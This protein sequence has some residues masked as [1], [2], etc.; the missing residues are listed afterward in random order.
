MSHC[1]FATTMSL[2]K[3]TDGQ[4]HS[5]P[6]RAI[7]LPI[8]VPFW[9]HHP[10]L[11]LWQPSVFC[12]KRAL[13]IGEAM[14]RTDLQNRVL[15]TYFWPNHL[16][17]NFLVASSHS[18]TPKTSWR[19]WKQSLG[20]QFGSRPTPV[21]RLIGVPNCSKATMSAAMSHSNTSRPKLRV[22]DLVGKTREFQ[23]E[24][25]SSLALK[26]PLYTDL[27]FRVGTCGPRVRTCCDLYMLRGVCMADSQ[28]PH[29]QFSRIRPITEWLNQTRI[30]ECLGPIWI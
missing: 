4:Q 12:G 27:A 15:S 16:W 3:Y 13:W 18:N 21:S 23:N 25:S 14:W 5:V 11:Y 19:P 28:V 24:D 9:S 8:Y 20:R 29:L 6:A 7:P 2:G 10:C 26:L 1:Y 17:G 22:P 30:L